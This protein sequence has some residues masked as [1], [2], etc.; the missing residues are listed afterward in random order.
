MQTQRLDFP[1]ASG[2]TLAGRLDLPDTPPR[3]Y[4]LF[5]HCFTCGKDIKA[6]S[7]IASALAEEGIATLR[8]DFTGLGGSEGEFG[9]TG[10]RSNIEDL[11]AAAA[12]MRETGRPVAI[13]IGHSLGGA[14][15]LA[16]AGDIPECRAVGTIAAPFDA[17]HVLA[18]LGEQRAEIEAEGEATVNLGGRAFRIRRAFIEQT[19][20]QDQGARIAHLHRPLLVLHAPLDRTVD[21]DNARRI[22]ETAKHPKSFVSLDSADHLLSDPADARYAATVIAAWAARY[23]PEPAGE[24]AASQGTEPGTVRVTETGT[25]R[26]QQRVEAGPHRLLADEPVANGGDDSGPDPY[27]YL[28]AGLGACTS[29]TIR[30][31]ARH[32]GI[33]LRSVQVTLRHEKIHAEDCE[34]CET[35]EGRIDRITRTIRLDGELTDAERARLLAIADRC[36][37]HRTLHSEVDVQTTESDHSSA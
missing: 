20:N 19:S 34:H 33:D 8:F 30:M 5:A 1:G 10:F 31:Y 26:F 25:G 11:T 15:V 22:F 16:A 35:R 24:D 4:A 2:Q 27:G 9:N 37:V 14:A 12:F 28:L 29:M 17:D 21:I 36:P 18:H 23:L 3:A 6:A 32:K 7:R 13:A